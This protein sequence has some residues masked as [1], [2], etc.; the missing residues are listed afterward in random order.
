MTTKIVIVYAV[1]YFI[2]FYV[3]ILVLARKVFFFF[4]NYVKYL[5]SQD[6]FSFCRLLVI[7]CLEFVAMTWD[8]KIKHHSKIK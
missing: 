8:K 3:A 7:D 1:I 2:T 4:S 6:G 5:I